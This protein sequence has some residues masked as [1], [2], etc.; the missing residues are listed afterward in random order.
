MKVEGDVHGRS[1]ERKQEHKVCCHPRLSSSTYK[2][3]TCQGRY[4]CTKDVEV[5]LPSISSSLLMDSRQII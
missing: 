5:C 3:G 2:S 1:S 4:I